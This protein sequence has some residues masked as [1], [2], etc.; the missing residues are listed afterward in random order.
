MPRD[1]LP[2]TIA[3]GNPAA[4]MRQ[5]FADDV[6]D[7][8]LAIAWWNWDIKQITRNLEIMLGEVSMP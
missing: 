6:I 8:L 4:P 1:A 2:Y 5:R 7:R 3:G